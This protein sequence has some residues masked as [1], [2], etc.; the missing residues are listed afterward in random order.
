[1]LKISGQTNEMKTFISFF[2]FVLLPIRIIIIF[3]HFS[4]FIWQLGSYSKSIVKGMPQKYQ[5]YVRKGAEKGEDRHFNNHKTKIFNSLKTKP[6]LITHRQNVN[7][8]GGRSEIHFNFY[9]N[10]GVANQK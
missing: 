9:S 2:L 7:Q 4:T 6:D 3:H 10:K 5:M 1:M 8:A